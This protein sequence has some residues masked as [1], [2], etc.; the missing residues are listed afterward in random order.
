MGRSTRLDWDL[1]ELDQISNYAHSPT[2][3]KKRKKKEKK[4]KEDVQ[5]HFYMYVRSTHTH[6]YIYGAEYRTYKHRRSICI[7]NIHMWLSIANQSGIQVSKLVQR[8][9][10]PLR[11]S[12]KINVKVVFKDVY[13]LPLQ[14][15]PK[16]GEE[17]LYWPVLRG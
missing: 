5:H 16:I 7:S 14:L 12:I 9:V 15:L 13:V 17:N 11:D 1:L 3:K 10:K 6:I 2:K 4:E 8:W